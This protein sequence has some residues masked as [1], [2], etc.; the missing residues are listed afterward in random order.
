M[1][2]SPT[3]EDPLEP[4]KTTAPSSPLLDEAERPHATPL[5]DAQTTQTGRASAETLV[6]V[7]EH[8]RHELRQIQEAMAAVAD[9]RLDPEV[10]RSVINRTALRQNAWALG[11]FC[12]Q[13]CRIVTAHHSMEDRYVFPS[14]RNDDVSLSA[15]L[16]RLGEEHEIIAEVL[17]RF[18]RALV[19]L[20]TNPKDLSGVQNMAEQLGD[21]LLS[22]LAYE[23]SELLGP[24]SRSSITV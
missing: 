5:A 17:D 1:N 23:E 16:T 21:A 4:P 15:V 2:G 9:G 7:H 20:I 19:A 13:Y 8:L 6:Q 22:H 3:Y 10:A 11:S 18:D 24:L 12:A 14:L